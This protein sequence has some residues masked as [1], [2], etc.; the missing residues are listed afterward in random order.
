MAVQSAKKPARIHDPPGLPEPTLSV[1]VSAFPLWTRPRNEVRL[2]AT[3]PE[4]AT[5]TWLVST[6]GGSVLPENIG[7]LYYLYGPK[8]KPGREPADTGVLLPNMLSAPIR[9]LS[10]G[11]F[12]F[13]APRAPE[14]HFQA[15][16]ETNASAQSV[17]ISLV[18][19]A[20][21]FRFVP[22]RAFV[23]PGGA[24]VFVNEDTAPHSVLETR[25]EH[26]ITQA[27]DI[28]IVAVDSGW[29]DLVALARNTLGHQGEAAAE[30]LADFESPVWRHTLGPTDGEVTLL[31]PHRVAL[32]Q[33]FNHPIQ[34]L[35]LTLT[36]GGLQISTNQVYDALRLDI[37]RDGEPIMSESTTKAGETYELA[38]LNPGSYTFEITLETGTR[39]VYELRGEALIL[40]TPP[41]R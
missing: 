36:R 9:L 17:E 32:R 16:V 21:G 12:T 15:Y 33:D 5:V 7:G 2:N 19:D 3:A 8:S 18:R 41:P 37:L 30:V 25:T 34:K 29:Y 11:R 24:I 38:N 6:P 4:D 23:A 40:A 26:T 10:E 35:T 14:T 13:T 28:R 39:T 31:A 20:F 27:T 1:D 22:D